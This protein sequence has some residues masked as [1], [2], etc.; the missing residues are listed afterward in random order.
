MH[1]GRFH[2]GGHA[3]IGFGY[4]PIWNLPDSYDYGYPVAGGLYTSPM[5]VEP[6][7]EAQSAYW[8]YCAD[9]RGY[10]P[11]VQQCPSGW[12]RV[13]PGPPNQ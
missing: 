3:F 8:Y 11:S 5:Y 13:V 9:S 4:W 10:Y 7:D 2:R 1:G 12:L 6:A